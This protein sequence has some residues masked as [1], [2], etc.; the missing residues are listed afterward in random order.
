MSETSKKPSSRSGVVAP[1]RAL[2]K[3]LLR[4]LNV[5]ENVSYGRNFRVGR[6]CVISSPHRL[7]IGNH[8]SIGPR[9]IVQ[10]DG[11]IG[12]WVL[13]GMGVQI[14]GRNDHL[15][16][17]IGVPVVRGTWVGDR[18]E[19]PKDSV[20]IGTDVWVGGGSVIM[21]GLTIGD[22]AIIASGSVVTKDVAPFSVVGGN[23]AKFIKRRFESDEEGLA[24]VQALQALR[25]V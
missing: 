3:W 2:A 16:S 13:I 20:K 11:L 6:S 21:S 1:A 4:K 23:P 24:H 12:D 5:H 15:T 22:G 18:A 19:S 9:T 14:V 25:G 8:V 17:G 7:T 10:V